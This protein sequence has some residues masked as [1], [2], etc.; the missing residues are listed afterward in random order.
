MK[1]TVTMAA[2]AALAACTTVEQEYLDALPDR[3]TVTVGLAEMNAQSSALHG[4]K[5]SALVGGAADFYT[6]SYYH[7]RELNNLAGFVL[8]V[9]E[10]VTAYPATEIAVDRVTWG[11]FSD[12]GEPNEW[13]VVITRGEIGGQAV[14]QWSIDGRHKGAGDFRAVAAGAYEPRAAP[15]GKG[16]FVLDFDRIGELEGKNDRGRIAYAYEK[17]ADGVIVLAKASV[18]EDDGSKVEAGYAYGKDTEG[19]GFI[20]FAFEADI[21]EDDPSKPAKEQVLLRTRWT[22]AGHGRADV[23]ASS[24]DLGTSRARFSQC[25]NDTF[26]STYESIRL[27]GNLLAEDGDVSTCSLRDRAEPTIDEIPGEDEVKNPHE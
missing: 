21:D 6:T 8:S 10:A 24:G 2:V 1:R 11:P 12:D 4:T 20:T 15:H 26:V 16:W 9:L 7:A 5:K 19:A 22:R 3:D 14:F 18:V 23:V 17:N 27:D 25:W 13:R